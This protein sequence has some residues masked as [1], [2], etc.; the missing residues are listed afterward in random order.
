[1]SVRG[2][3]AAFENGTIRSGW[4][5]EDDEEEGETVGKGVKSAGTA[6]NRSRPGMP[7][8]SVVEPDEDEDDGGGTVKAKGVVQPREGDEAEE[9]READAAVASLARLFPDGEAMLDTPFPGRRETSTATTDDGEGS[10]IYRT[11]IGTL[12]LLPSSTSGTFKRASTINFRGQDGRLS[13]YFDA[14]QPN[15]FLPPPS[16]PEVDKP[17]EQTTPP[18][19]DTGS[20]TPPAPAATSP[21]ASPAPAS[22]ALAAH[23]PP[24]A[25]L[26]L[27]LPSFA[28]PA[29]A[30]HGF[31]G[32]PSFGELTFEQGT[33]L[34]IEVE[35]LGGGWSLGYM[36]SKGEDGRGLVPRGWYAYIDPPKPPSPVPAS[37]APPAVATEVPSS[38]SVSAAVPAVPAAV[39]S[40]QPASPSP[41]PS[42]DRS[43]AVEPTLPAAVEL[44]P[45]SAAGQSGEEPLSSAA[46]VEDAPRPPT[47]AATGT[48]EEPAHLSSPS[49]VEDEPAHYPTRSIGRHVVVSGIEFE[50]IPGTPQV[51]EDGFAF[52]GVGEPSVEE[53]LKQEETARRL[54]GKAES[55]GREQVEDGEA[56]EQPPSQREE[57]DLPNPPSPPLAPVEDPRPLSR[58]PTPIASLPPS[59]SPRPAPVSG[60][61]L[62]RLGLSAPSSAFSLSL[63]LPGRQTIPGASVLAATSASPTAGLRGGKKRLPR[64]EGKPLEGGKERTLRWV[65]EGD[66]LDDKVVEEQEAGEAGVQ[67][68]DV[69]AGPSWRP[70]S[71]PFVV[72]VHSPVKHSPLNDSPY[73]SY[74]L[75][76]VFAPSDPSSEADEALS[77]TVTRRFSHFTALHALLSAR[78]FVPL[79]MIPPLPPKALGAGRFAEGFVE[80]RRRDLE[81]WLEKL[82]RHPVVGRSEELRDFLQLEDEKELLAHLRLRPVS[83]P[84]AP[85]PLFP[86]RVFHPEFN[87]DL[88][89][90]E[91]LV[92]RFER[93]CKAIEV[94]GGWKEVELAVG[95]EREG[96]RATATDLQLLSHSLIRLAAGQALPHTSHDKP[97]SPDVEGAHTRESDVARQQ[98]R[99]REWGL[100]N[101]KGGLGWKEEDDEALCVSKALQATAEVL[102]NAADVYDDAARTALL[103]VHGI[104]HEGSAPLTQCSPLIDLHRALLAEYRRLSRMSADPAAHEALS[105]CE[106]ALNISCAEMDRI[107]VERAWDLRVA[108]EKWL[109]A[110]IQLQEQARRAATVFI[111]SQAFYTAVTLD[112]LRYARDHFAPAAYPSLALTGPRLRSTLETRTSPP[113]YPP[114]P[115][116]T[117]P[118]V[119]AAVGWAGVAVGSVFSP[120]SASGSG[121]LKRAQTVTGAPR[122]REAPAYALDE[123]DERAEGAR[124]RNATWTESIFGGTMR[125]W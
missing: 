11:P 30:L 71:E 67:V 1:M 49:E 62:F 55:V 92:E 87:V 63:P 46:P 100:Q 96:Q 18:T 95:K 72:H 27:P 40:L 73:T 31:V 32:E 104:L 97:A 82:A 76:T 114:L 98:R 123:A 52:G 10:G 43:G 5:E 15:P 106:T 33:P 24:A 93:H 48:A 84:P 107:R 75:T 124:A 12:R 7:R 105:R 74:S 47:P 41:P 22:P 37:P 83:P 81:R 36:E 28:S 99:A 44:P 65:R 101:E 94:G 111:P 53:L 116:P 56:D 90:A 117:G 42:P 38:P 121:A 20:S 35:D 88:A 86:S 68:W 19:S 9:K 109:D 16:S 108:V 78:F 51:E 59:P 17:A 120:T 113:V 115:Q 34:R 8:W 112:H 66:E 64:Y 25:D 91:E 14:N 119:S 50:P 125:L 4:G 61:F 102:A 54:S 85:L 39:A 29:V 58:A 26:L 6:S 21:P 3:A 2:R 80:Q 70:P 69:E 13:V 110:Q 89:E 77:L 103:A 79:V 23:D 45:A 118:L 122:S 57:G 60:S